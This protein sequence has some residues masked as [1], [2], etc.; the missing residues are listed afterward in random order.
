MF[1][2]AKRKSRSRDLARVILRAINLVQTNQINFFV[3]IR[4]SVIGYYL[5]KLVS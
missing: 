3:V 4:P 1:A 5:D 2:G